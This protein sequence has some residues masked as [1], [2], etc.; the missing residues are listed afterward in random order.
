[1]V[2]YDINKRGSA[3]EEGAIFKLTGFDQATSLVSPHGAKFVRIQFGWVGSGPAASL[4]LASGRSGSLREPSEPTRQTGFRQ[5]WR[6]S[7]ETKP[8]A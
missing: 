3:E 7:G 1:M 4:R 5:I 6:R 2:S 8:V